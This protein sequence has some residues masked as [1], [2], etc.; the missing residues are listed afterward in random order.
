MCR[1]PLACGAMSPGCTEGTPLGALCRRAR[2]RQQIVTGRTRLPVLALG[3]AISGCSQLVGP[4]D[5][6]GPPPPPSVAGLVTGNAAAALDGGGR[7][8]WVPA[9][10]DGIAVV[11]RDFA[12]TLA[13]GMVKT[14]I[15]NSEVLPG[16]ESFRETA[17]WHHGSPIDWER[18][19]VG[20]RPA[21]LASSAHHNPG[22]HLDPVLRRAMGPYWLVP[23][24]VGAV[25]V[26][27]IEV[28]AL[29]DN[30]FLD[31]N[32]FVRKR[33]GPR[34]GELRIAGVA[35]G[36]PVG[37]PLSPEE[38][39]LIV[40]TRTGR[41]V[42]EIPEL[43]LPGGPVVGAFSRWR[44]KLEAPVRVRRVADGVERITDVVYAGTY[45]LGEAGDWRD[46]TPRLFIPSDTLPEW[47]SWPAPGGEWVDVPVRSGHAL[48]VVEVEV[49]P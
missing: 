11:G 3:L 20:P 5:L 37:V 30:L 25:Q 40:A 34:G 26:A 31:G 10:D 12:G 45:N 42:S 13:V 1:R 36:A 44:V 35:R 43:R 48:H 15:L 16:G 18:V 33:D 38:A 23:L 14:W 24:Y 7:F 19:E 32:G 6:A 47:V 8:R 41:R 21:Y 39:V 17:E 49:L 46:V 2:V 29:A 9:E 28:S 22:E 27:V 4:D